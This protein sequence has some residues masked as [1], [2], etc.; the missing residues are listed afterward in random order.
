MSSIL[1]N[2]DEDQ[3]GVLRVLRTRA[4]ARAFYNKIA[5]VY[6]SFRKAPKNLPEVW[7]GPAR[8]ERWQTRPRGFGT[9]TS[10]VA[11]AR[12]VGAGA[13]RFVREVDTCQEA[14]RW[15]FPLYSDA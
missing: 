13:T 9:S 7:I 3:H 1:N 6:V 8:R 2:Q 14:L 15:Y 5:R 12:M 4:K 11:L 10:L